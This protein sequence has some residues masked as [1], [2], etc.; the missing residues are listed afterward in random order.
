MIVF[1]N[2]HYVPEEQAVVSVLD[3]GFLYGD[4]LFET[5]LVHH[6]CPFRWEQHWQR[7]QHGAEQ[8]RLSLPFAAAEL[9]QHA[10]EL[11]RRNQLPDC[12]LR[13]TLTRGV[14]P[15]GY[16]IKGAN[17]PVL[18]MTLHPAPSINLLHP[19]QWRLMTSS[20][21]VAPCDPLATIKTCN[22]LAQ[23]IARTEAEEHGANEA[24]L[25]NTDGEVAEAGSSNLFWIEQEAVCTTPLDSGALAGVTRAFVLELCQALGWQSMEKPVRPEV[26]GKS[27]GVFL[28]LSTLGIVEVSHLDEKPLASSLLIGKLRSAY[29]QALFAQTQ[30]PISL[31]ELDTITIAER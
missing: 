8:L 1:L 21:R 6:G 18:T 19:P 10:N 26:L 4:G 29:L 27:D 2:G 20:I 23:I 28:T 30:R 14:G 9:R 3:R 7:L 24:L 17:R 25:L 5:L 11:I 13:L 16:S 31:P 15:R 12:V 22:K